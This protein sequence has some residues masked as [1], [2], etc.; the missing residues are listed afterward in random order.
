MSYNVLIVDDSAIVRAAV[1]NSLT[2]TGLEI[3]ELYEA[4]NGEEALTQLKDNWIDIVFI[5]SSHRQL[6]I[7]RR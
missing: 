1:K 2:M 5:N 4:A 3:N 6:Y 7:V